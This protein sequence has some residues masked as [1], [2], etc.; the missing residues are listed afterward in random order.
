MRCNPTRSIAKRLLRRAAC[1]LRLERDRVERGVDENCFRYKIKYC[2]SGNTR[3]DLGSF[4]ELLEL[5]RKAPLPIGA[6]ITN[7]ARDFW[8]LQK[9]KREGE[10]RYNAES[11]E[12]SPSVS[13][14]LVWRISKG[15]P[16]ESVAL[17]PPPHMSSTF[18]L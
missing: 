14:V 15:V 11:C 9:N 7:G 8:S 1:P 12:E 3:A 10:Q 6:D 13:K 16:G 5:R 17:H 18:Q 2:A 4:A